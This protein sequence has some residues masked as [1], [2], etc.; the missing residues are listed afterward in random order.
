MKEEK[1]IP[2]NYKSFK[3]AVKEYQE[4][5]N[6][7][8]SISEPKIINNPKKYNLNDFIKEYPL[9]TSEFIEKGLIKTLIFNAEKRI[10]EMDKIDGYSYITD[11]STGD[12]S[13]CSRTI[14]TAIKGGLKGLLIGKKTLK[15]K[16]D[17]DLIA[18]GLVMLSRLINR[19][20]EI[21]DDQ[22]EGQWYEL[23]TQIEYKGKSYIQRDSLYHPN[24]T[25]EINYHLIRDATKFCNEIY[26]K[27]CKKT[28]VPIL[29]GVYQI[30]CSKCGYGLT[31]DFFTKE[32]LIYWLKEGEE[33]DIDEELKKKHKNALRTFEEKVSKR[34]EIKKGNT[35]F[36]IHPF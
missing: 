11:V 8:L 17:L 25:K 4:A 16:R 7:P 24:G 22:W 5:V 15:H 30:A 28:R 1:N 35:T 26:C 29:V 33:L 3:E 27:Y 23:K 31:P 21:G 19:L 36:I 18:E 20:K 13:E 12:F 10:K 6:D 14:F 2:E 9:L 32:E 34:I